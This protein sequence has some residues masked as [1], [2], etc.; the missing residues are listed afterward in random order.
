MTSVARRMRATPGFGRGLIGFRS[1]RRPGGFF[2]RQ[3]GWH[4]HISYKFYLPEEPL[5]LLRD[6]Q[7]LRSV[8][9]KGP[10]HQR[11]GFV[12][13]PS[14]LMSRARQRARELA[15]TPEFVHAQRQRKKVEAL[16]AEHSRIRLGYGACACGD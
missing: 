14:T 7:A 16:F 9:A 1:Y 4:D 5:C 11:S 13:L 8:C 2:R 6:S 15:T 3:P 12:F 10:M